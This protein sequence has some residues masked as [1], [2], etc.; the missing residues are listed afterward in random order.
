MALAIRQRAPHGEGAD[1]GCDFER[2]TIAVDAC[3]R[4][5][6]AFLVRFRQVEHQHFGV[7]AP[8]SSGRAVLAR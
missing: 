1:R 2:S 3:D 8:F 5:V 4:V 6:I 7:A